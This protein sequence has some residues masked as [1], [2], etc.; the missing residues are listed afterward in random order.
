MKLLLDTHL[1]LWAAGRPAHFSARARAL[2]KDPANQL[3]FS[4]A[5]PWETAIEINF[6]MRVCVL[7]PL[8]QKA[9]ARGDEPETEF[10]RGTDGE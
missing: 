10:R 6:L 8:L 3:I 4:A 1:L 5:S 2:L 7:P 9:A